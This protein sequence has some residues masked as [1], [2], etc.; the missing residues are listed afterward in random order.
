VLRSLAR[1]CL[2]AAEAW[3]C[4]GDEDACARVVVPPSTS[5]REWVRLSVHT[6]CAQARVLC[7]WVCCV[8]SALSISS[9]WRDA[10]W[11]ARL[12]LGHLC[13]RMRSTCV[14]ACGRLCQIG[15]SRVQSSTCE[16]CCVVCCRGRLCLHQAPDCHRAAA[17][18][19]SS[20]HCSWLNRPRRHAAGLAMLQACGGVCVAPIDVM[21]ALLSLGCCCCID[22]LEGLLRCAP[23]PKS[24]PFSC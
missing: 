9:L 22:A 1:A 19:A 17:R 2:C 8:L 18:F 16:A 6:R 15:C 23:P 13:V 4:H 14:I 7:G 24:S 20:R 10:C 11:G 5:A 21:G 12:C 3:G